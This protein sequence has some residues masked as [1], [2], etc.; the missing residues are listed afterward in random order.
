MGKLKLDPLQTNLLTVLYKLVSPLSPLPVQTVDSIVFL[1]PEEIIYITTASS[2][3]DVVDQAGAAWRRFDTIT[4]LVKRF[5]TDPYFFKASRGSI[6]NLRQ[7]RTLK[8]TSTGVHEVTFTTLSADHKVAIADSV[9]PAFKRAMGLTIP[10][11]R[12]K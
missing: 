3:L 11:P 4:A 12:K 5:K 9:F 1:K 6:I 7:V 10:E 8:T 2:S